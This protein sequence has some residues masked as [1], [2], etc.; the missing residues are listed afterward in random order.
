VVVEEVEVEVVV[1]AGVYRLVDGQH[2]GAQQN[3]QG[4]AQEKT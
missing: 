3:C 4:G 1:V 2:L